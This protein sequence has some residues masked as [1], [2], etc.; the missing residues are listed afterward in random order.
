VRLLGHWI[1][2]PFAKLIFKTPGTGSFEVRTKSWVGWLAVS[3]RLSV[4]LRL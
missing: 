2:V 3:R 4:A 1:R